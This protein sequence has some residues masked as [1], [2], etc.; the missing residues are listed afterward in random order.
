MNMW[1][2]IKYANLLSVQ[3]ENYTVKTNNPYLANFRCPFCGDSQKSKKKIRG[4][5][6]TKTTSLFYK[7]H[8][9]G[10]GTTLG[11]V[12]KQVNPSLFNEYKLERYKEGMDIG[13]AAK[14]HAR[15]EFQNFSPQFKERSPL[16]RLFDSVSTL[17]KHNIGVRYLES[18][19]IPRDKWSDIYFAYETKKLVELCPDYDEIVQYEE[20]RIILPFM[21]RSNDLVGVSARAVEKN[22]LRYLTLRIDKN[23]PLIYNVNNVDLTKQIY[24]VEGPLDSLFLDNAVA[25]G[26]ADLARVSSILP[27]GNTTLVFDN[28]PRNPEVVRIM[29][30]AMDDG[31]K[32][33][34]W[35]DTIEEK[36][37]NDM[38]L[39]GKSASEIQEVIN[40]NSHSGLSLHLKLNA[41][42]KC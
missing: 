32:I 31:W 35:P 38:V 10:V 9:C 36:D 8:N 19:M 24:C 7:C 37:I 27:K 4:Y 1:I 20:P 6:Y 17:P 13:N 11:N 21:S 33:V 29:K 26:S 40:M 39:S 42:S 25:V 15:V 3:L 30:R 23:T 16:E 28:Q 34:I 18:R 5:L 12:I 22:N 2:D 14:P 41:W